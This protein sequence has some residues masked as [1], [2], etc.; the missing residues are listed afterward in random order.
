MDD[1]WHEGRIET[2][3]SKSGYGYLLSEAH[4]RVL[5]HTGSLSPGV[6]VTELR[7]D[8]QVRF[9]IDFVRTGPVARQL[10]VLEEANETPAQ[11]RPPSDSVTTHRILDSA[12]AAPN[13]L[14]EI[15]KRLDSPS[16]YMAAALVQREKKQMALAREIYRK[17]LE[18]APDPTLILSY[19]AL[20]RS[21]NDNEAARDVFRRG[22]DFFPNHPKLL[23]DAGV[24]ELKTGNANQAR[25]Y[26]Q[27]ALALH[28]SRGTRGNILR[29]LADATYQLATN[30]ESTPD[31]ALLNDAEQDL[32]S[33][34]RLSGGLSRRDFILL[35]RIRALR[36]NPNLRWAFH[37]FEEAGF[38]IVHILR[39]DAH[40]VDFLILAKSEE[41]ARTYKL[42]EP[43][44]VRYL[45]S[46]PSVYELAELDRRIT[47]LTEEDDTSSNLAFV[48]L[49]SVA[50][51]MVALRRH[52]ES[53]GQMATLVPF[54]A[55]LL[56]DGQTPGSVVRT[57]LDQW[58]FRR[59][60]YH[61]N[62]PVSGSHFF[63]RERQLKALFTAVNEG[64]HVGIFGLRKVGKT[65]F[66]WRVRDRSYADLVAYVDLLVVPAAVKNCDY[67]YWLIGNQLAEDFKRKCP[68]L[69]P[70]SHFSLFGRFVEYN[71]LIGKPVSLLFDT[72]LSRLRRYLQR[73][74]FES[75]PKMIILIDE[76]E[77][78]MPSGDRATGFEGYRDFF[79]Y[80]RGQAQQYRDVVTV[81]TGANAAIAEQPQWDGVDNPVYS[82]YSEEFLSALDFPECSKM[83]SE[84]GAGMGVRFE[85]V[86]LSAIYN[87][88]G[89]HP[90]ITRRFCSR[91]C[92]RRPARPLLVDDRGVRDSVGT[93][94][95]DDAEL[96]DEILERLRRDF[97]DELE[98]LVTIARN[99][100]V[101][102][103]DVFQK[104]SQRAGPVIN[105]LIGYQ[106]IRAKA[107]RYSIAIELLRLHITASQGD[108]MNA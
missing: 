84:L 50:R 13:D 97:P 45:L 44:L 75:P 41:L 22:L 5:V 10:S 65:S 58:L 2:F 47:Q 49:K 40:A 46:D 32:A 101:G 12:P 34:E 102:W 59:D 7:P 105:H 14:D 90:F 88:T 73:G 28:P 69:A 95:R 52:L 43:I 9:R 85:P 1:Q 66:L 57:V 79:G 6:V 98:L 104:L 96:F 93:F 76:V 106:V 26:F 11:P 56:R 16:D 64:R 61:D 68:G 108:G 36:I 23:E 81:I 89:G 25:E 91:I 100:D 19:A 78:L 103:N 67:V 30:S 94:L 20:E 74:D 82:F 99:G 18:L 55:G 24:L 72:D 8:V 80:W 17:G 33:A 38:H 15:L 27:R 3:K 29:W 4:G 92:K 63:G 87:L 86:A 83:I 39:P 107:D 37:F 48:V 60:L 77:R 54:E 31:A 35:N 42:D 71:S 51:V 62:F 70:T 53:A 21:N